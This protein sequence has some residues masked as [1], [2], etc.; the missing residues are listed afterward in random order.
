M[1]YNI[2]TSLENTLFAVLPLYRRIF[3][4]LTGILI[5][6]SIGDTMKKNV[7]STKQLTGIA[8][9]V[10]LVI[11]L[12]SIST[13]VPFVVQLNLALIPI[14]LGALL[15]G[16]GAGAL[17]GFACGVVVLIQVMTVPSTFYT[18]I[19]TYDP[20]VTTLTCLVKTTVAGFVAGLL[21]QA[22]QR[23][24]KL[25]AVFVA[26]A[27]VPVIN[28]SLFV[29]GCLFMVN[30]V[31]QMAGGQNV[32]T[33]ILVGLVTW[34]FFFELLANLLIAPALYRVITIVEKDF[35]RKRK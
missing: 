33:F 13:V 31:Y 17:I 20:V 18:L 6:N 9:L 27:V 4:R 22:L 29:V 30:S 35:I 21:Y 1:L 7:F 12:Q 16:A 5:K 25:L 3:F 28:T 34:N 26:A 23:K 2:S 19:W 10:A 11:V 15:F 14:V 8:V 32:L 24:N